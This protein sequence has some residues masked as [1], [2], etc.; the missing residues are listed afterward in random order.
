MTTYIGG[1]GRNKLKAFWKY[2]L[3]SQKV[4][5]VNFKTKWVVVAHAFNP[6]D[7][8]TEAGGSLRSKLAGLQSWFHD[9]TSCSEKTKK[10]IKARK[11]SVT[12]FPFK[13]T[14]NIFE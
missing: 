7:Q 8:K 11:T 6:S 5:K 2:P 3:L 9:N 14:L 10:K 4:T 13:N 1:T 12:H